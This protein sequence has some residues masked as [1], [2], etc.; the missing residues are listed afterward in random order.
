MSI[1]SDFLNK[2][3]VMQQL[4]EWIDKWDCI[5]LKSSFAQQRKQSLDLRQLAEWRKFLP[6]I[7]MHLIRY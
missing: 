2:T 5:K 1:G 6:A 3:P 4:R 7:S